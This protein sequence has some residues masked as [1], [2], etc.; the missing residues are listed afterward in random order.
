MMM[1]RIAP[2]LALIVALTFALPAIA[3]TSAHPP[4]QPMAGDPARGGRLYQSR[5]G[6]CHS[7]DANRIGP[8]HRGVFGRR[9]A[10]APGFHYSPALAARRF[11]WDEHNLDAWLQSP[12]RFVPGTAM[13]I[14]VPDAQE[15]TDIIAYLRTQSAGR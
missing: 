2:R 1:N 9:V 3:Q 14:G 10:T 12:T 7:I 13:G 8:A 4:Q 11:V 15:R 5:C 6:A